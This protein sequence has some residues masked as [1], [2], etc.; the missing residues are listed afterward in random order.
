M[1]DKYFTVNNLK[2]MDKDEQ[3]YIWEESLYDL[4]SDFSC[5]GWLVRLK[6]VLKYPLTIP[7]HPIRKNYPIPSTRIFFHW[8]LTVIWL[9]KI[10]TLYS[11]RMTASQMQKRKIWLP[12]I[13]QPVQD[14]CFLQD[15][16]HYILLAIP[17]TLFFLPAFPFSDYCLKRR[18]VQSATDRPK[19]S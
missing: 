10:F 18:K 16:V 3:K 6:S 8:C 11:F 17:D 1:S 2:Y 14:C 13:N 19:K 4:L 12:Y 9:Y 15:L 7:S 5:P